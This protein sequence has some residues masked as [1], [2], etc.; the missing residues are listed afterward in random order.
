MLDI[1]LLR[2]DLTERRGHVW[3]T[4]KN[5]ASPSSTKT[6]YAV[7]RDRA[8]R[9]CRCAPR[10]CRASR[11]SLSK[12]IGHVEGQGRRRRRPCWPKSAGIGRRA[13]G[14]G[15]APGRDP[16]RA[17]N[18]MLMSVPNLPH[19]S[20]PVGSDESRQCR[21]APLGQPA[22]QFDFTPSSDHVDLGGPLGL[23][24]ETGAKLSGLALFSFLQRQG[25]PP[26]P[27]TGPVHAGPADTSSMATPSATRLIS[28]TARCWKARASCPSSRRT[29]FGSTVAAKAAVMSTA[30]EQYLISTSEISLTNSV[31]E[32]RAGRRRHAAD[33]ADRAQPLLPLAKP[34]VQ[35][36]T[37]VA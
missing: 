4:R 30:Q 23:D 27:G 18:T 33:Q 16:D 24:F 34:A 17:V 6:R 2:K 37:P 19:E 20:V 36:V 25:R 10:N 12:Q 7:A 15:R 29:C 26:A 9:P 1:N 3:N 28:S 22:N 13:E 32:Q 31:R 35:G 14:R 8:Q 21:G 5:A 11:N